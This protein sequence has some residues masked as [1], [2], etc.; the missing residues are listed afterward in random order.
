MIYVRIAQRIQQ[1]YLSLSLPGRSALLCIPPL[2]HSPIPR[3]PST[4]VVS[5][6]NGLRQVDH[7]P[8][9]LKLP[10][11]GVLQTRDSARC[12]QV[13]VVRTEGRTLGGWAALLNQLWKISSAED[14]TGK[15][16]KPSASW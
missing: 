10:R 6:Q 9:R 12:F 5:F 8:H 13:V 11:A 4:N 3:G 15:I 7:L 14:E 2:S 1:S 16:A